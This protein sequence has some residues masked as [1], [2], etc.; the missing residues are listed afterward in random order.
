MDDNQSTTQVNPSNDNASTQV[1]PEMQMQDMPTIKFGNSA[2]AKPVMF[3]P[4]P[5][6]APIVIENKSDSAATESQAET[7]KP[8]EGNIEHALE[9][10]ERA[11]RKEVKPIAT[12]VPQDLPTATVNP[13]QPA[14]T[15]AVVTENKKLDL[16]PF[17]GYEIAE[18]M[19]DLDL[20]AANKGKKE[21][22]LADTAIW[23]FLDRLLKKGNEK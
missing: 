19:L 11:E 2:T 13:T 17:K 21:K 22:N 16:P 18:E 7:L 9:S 23:L 6:S 10:L 4:S 20:I 1:V 3:S 12:D 14:Q 15:T 8:V 5:E